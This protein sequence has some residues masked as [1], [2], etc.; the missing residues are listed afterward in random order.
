[1]L[2]RYV[3]L[4]KTSF[5]NKRDVSFELELSVEQ[6]QVKKIKYQRGGR[7]ERNYNLQKKLK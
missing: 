6:R 5:W 7:A 3:E 1:M 4:I 2:A